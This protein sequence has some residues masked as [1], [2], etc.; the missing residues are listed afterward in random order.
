MIYCWYAGLSIESDPLGSSATVTHEIT[1][2]NTVNDLRGPGSQTS[3]SAGA[4]DVTGETGITSGKGYSGKSNGGVVAIGSNAA[5]MI[6]VTYS[7]LIKPVDQRSV[8]SVSQAIG[9]SP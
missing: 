9:V 5:M 6:L 1:N 4:F 3:F 7:K 8:G 2:A